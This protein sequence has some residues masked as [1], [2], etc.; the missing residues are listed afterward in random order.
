[1]YT[2]VHMST[3]QCTLYKMPGVFFH[4]KCLANCVENKQFMIRMA[5]SIDTDS[6]LQWITNFQ[7][8]QHVQSYMTDMNWFTTT[9]TTTPWASWMLLKGRVK[10]WSNL[11]YSSNCIVASTGGSHYHMPATLRCWLLHLQNIP[12]IFSRCLCAPILH[13]IN[14]REQ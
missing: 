2:N 9:T 4:S 10:S 8:T 6:L 1:M 12:E 14:L 5:W 3:Y 13:P 11:H 7:L